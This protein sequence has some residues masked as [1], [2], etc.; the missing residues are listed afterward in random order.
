MQLAN[1]EQQ[2]DSLEFGDRQLAQPLL[3]KQRERPHP[4]TGSVYFGDIT[5]N[6]RVGLSRNIKDDH[7]DV[8][9]CYQFG[10]IAG[11]GRS[12]VGRS[13]ASHDLRRSFSRCS[14]V[15]RERP[16]FFGLLGDE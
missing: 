15:G 9:C 16:E 2:R 12:Q 4:D 6:T 3:V 11:L 7:A 13:L 8:A 14:Q 5:N 10:Q 1:V